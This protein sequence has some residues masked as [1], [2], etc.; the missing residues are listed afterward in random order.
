MTNKEIGSH[1]QEL[2][3][4]MEL[5]QENVF[6]IRTYQN[7]Y[8]TLRKLN[9]DVK[10][11]SLDELKAIKGIGSAV[12]NKIRELVESGKMKTLE[13]YRDM[14]PVGI[15]ELVK[16]RG[17][18]PKKILPLWKELG[19]ENTG[20]LLYAIN[21]NRLIEL[22][23]F[24]LKTQEDILGKLKYF[25]LSKSKFLLANILPH[26]KDLITHIERAYPKAHT[27]LVG[28]IRRK[29]PVIQSIELLIDQPIDPDNIE[30]LELSGGPNLYT[31]KYKQRFP[32]QIH[33]HQDSSTRGWE[34]LSKTG[35]QEY[36][37][38]ADQKISNKLVGDEKSLYTANQIPYHPPECRDLPPLDIP[39]ERDLISLED[40]TG[41]L[42]V[43]ST[44]SDGI[45]NLS[46]LAAHCHDQG[47]K[48][49]GITDHS[50]SAVYAQG[51]NINKLKEQWA[52]IDQLNEQR[53]Q[54]K[55][56]KGIESDILNDG[57]LDYPDEILKQFDFVIASVHSQL[58]MDKATATR[59]IITAIEHPAT[60][61][62]GHPSGRLL[63]SRPGYELDFQA[64]IEACAANQVAIEI[65]ANPYRLDLDYQWIPYAIK[66]GVY[67]SINPDAHS[68]R[69]IKDIQYG[70]W[71][72]RKGGLK[73]TD[74]LNSLNLLRLKNFFQK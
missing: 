66:K 2:A 22:K 62:L 32:L 72:A 46:E 3:L 33:V 8:L 52:E 48:Y 15:Q 28:E 55:I 7:V 20:E 16:I 13:R 4:L 21:E 67:L 68:Q 49:L 65:N 73:K 39:A 61:I 17:L 60:N 74:C 42:H 29:L 58:K 44:Y 57:S 40:I 43:H 37:A 31:G 70:V 35:N 56:F 38:W 30:D 47:F 53:A 25:S 59:R 71:T 45:N 63:L 6:K 64:V 14:T 5:H 51:L 69:G 27:T 10:D 12:A 36:V 54:F 23:G 50:R 34:V 18:G 41:I 26:C 1:F 9:E 24:G 19:I 11:L